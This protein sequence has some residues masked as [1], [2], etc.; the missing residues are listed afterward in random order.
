MHCTAL[1]YAA[2]LAHNGTA[3]EDEIPQTGPGK[4][5]APGGGCGRGWGDAAGLH[6]AGWVP[7]Q[8]LDSTDRPLDSEAGQSHLG[9][10][11]T[12]PTSLPPRE[13]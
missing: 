3:T 4:V 10:L 6:Y 9:P 13:T 5:N 11:S 8:T 1:H 7:E 12:I 2:A